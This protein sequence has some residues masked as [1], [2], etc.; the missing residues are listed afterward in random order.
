[1]GRV[2]V[3]GLN[4]WQNRDG[5]GGERERTRK[6]GSVVPQERHRVLEHSLTGNLVAKKCLEVKKLPKSPRMYED[7]RVGFQND[8]RLR[9]GKQKKKKKRVPQN[10][11]ERCLGE[12]KHT[13]DRSR[14]FV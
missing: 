7:G 14:I 1:M 3:L 2:C 11:H 8:R 4:V 10:D 9:P 5:R 6:T 13:S 12:C